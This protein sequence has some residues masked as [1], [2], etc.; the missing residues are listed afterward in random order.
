[1][2]KRPEKLVVNEYEAAA[3]LGMST[4]TLQARR[5]RH[6]PPQYYKVGR[7]IRYKV[8]DLIDWIES[9]KVQVGEV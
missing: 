2:Q 3:M 6:L 9:G 5:Y 8:S 7:S 4:K 1:M